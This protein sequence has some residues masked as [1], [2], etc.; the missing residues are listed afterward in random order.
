MK[1]AGE[2]LPAVSRRLKRSLREWVRRRSIRQLVR[3]LQRAKRRPAQAARQGVKVRQRLE[4][5]GGFWS[6]AREVLA[7]RLDVFPREFC[8]ELEGAVEGSGARPMNDARAVV[9]GALGSLLE[10]RLENFDERPVR[11]SAFGQLHTATL[12][13]NGAPV[14]VVVR[15]PDAESQLNDE[16]K[17][18]ELFFGW[19]SRARG[20]QYAPWERLMRELRASLRDGLDFRIQAHA[21]REL[22]KQVRR[23]PG[24]SYPR[25]YQQLCS[26]EVLVAER[27][28][29]PTLAEVEAR[30][31]DIGGADAWFEQHQTDPELLACRLWKAFMRQLVE[32]RTLVPAQGTQDIILLGENEFC[33]RFEPFVL[34][35]ELGV[36]RS[37]AFHFLLHSLLRRSYEGAFFPLLRLA[38][39]LP[40]LEPNHLKKVVSR[41]IRAWAQRAEVKTLPSDSRSFGALFETVLST[42]Q[43][44]PIVFDSAV[45]RAC[46]ELR[47]LEGALFVL[48]PEFAVASELRRFFKRSVRRVARRLNAQAASAQPPD[49]DAV[50]QVPF[51]AMEAEQGLAEQGSRASLP[52]ASEPTPAAYLVSRVAEFLS[53]VFLA[54]IV[55][56]AVVAARVTSLIHL[57]T[58]SWLERTLV[59]V[60]QPDPLELGLTVLIASFS[61]WRLRR[62][63]VRFA[64][65]DSH[66]PTRGV[67]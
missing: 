43:R 59:G 29:G 58:D 21:M 53:F 36:P 4:A 39:P 25:V 50:S 45:L 17:E 57:S 27:V 10:R 15:R 37:K 19:L 18:M 62:L 52:F 1:I 51:T 67:V 60:T 6:R 40:P 13:K 5:L 46:Q 33:Y 9:A 47:R 56:L 8:R 30:G 12:K 48:H 44:H 66:L 7:S 64:E 22:R 32:A 26:A 65:R 11:I 31:E 55:V 20:L 34:P 61:A 42:M 23:Y 54:A 24:A 14:W 28:Q 41:E 38:E 49:W 3:M 16:L 35:I 63:A 2:W